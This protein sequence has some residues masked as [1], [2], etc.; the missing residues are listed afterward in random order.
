MEYQYPL[1]T[2]WSSKEIIDVINFYEAIER[3]YEQG[4]NKEELLDVYRRFKEIV[5]SKSEEKKLCDEFEKVSSYSAYRLIKRAK[6]VND[7]EKIKMSLGQKGY[8]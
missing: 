5:P 4:I 7:G 3:A 6:E 8:F 2:D 1:S